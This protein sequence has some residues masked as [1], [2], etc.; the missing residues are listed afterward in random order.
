MDKVT[1]EQ[2]DCLFNPQSIAVIGAADRYDKRGKWAASWGFSILYQVL[3]TSSP[4]KIYAVNR[5]SSAV[6]NLKC[7]KSILDVPEPVDLAVVV[8]PA[9]NVPSAIR[10][11][12]DKK[13]KNIIIISGGF[14]ELNIEG[15]EVQ[16][17]LLTM[18]RGANVRLLG[19]NCMGHFNTHADLSTSVVLPGKKGGVG[20]IS[21]SGNVGSAII[22]NGSRMGIG[23]SK[24][25]STGNEADLHLEDF[26]EYLADDEE[27][28]VITLYVEGLREGKRFMELAKE[29]TK[30]KPVIAFKAGSTEAGTRAAQ[31]HTAA[32]TGTDEIYQ[33]AF[34]Q[35]GI[36]Q[37][38][39]IDELVN[40]A[41]AL[42]CQPLPRSRRVAILTLGGGLGVVAADSCERLN[43]EVAPLLPQTI[44]R[45]NSLLPGIW[46]HGNPVDT[47]GTLDPV[48][49]CLSAL[50]EDRNIDSVL[51][52][53]PV[54]GTNIWDDMTLDEIEKARERGDPGN[55]GLIIKLR[56]EC[57][58]PVIICNLGMVIEQPTQRD[59]Q[60]YTSMERAVRVLAHLAEY[61][62][63][64]NQAKGEKNEP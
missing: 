33:A 19:P 29:I 5:N 36:I 55:L 34:K 42:L 25:I 23:F 58:K 63:Y 12:L 60:I 57:Q 24:Y 4:R 62:K 21:Q 44:D 13:V 61:S 30:R 59:I 10:E 46:S 14:S 20:V 48:F 11:C 64:L 16:Q 2:L 50:L 52:N 22:I 7:Y 49:P 17:E 41:G 9:H 45:L 56:N 40:I 1:K 35:A 54:F 26:L 3:A 38:R 39:S 18:A 27:T 31:S 43:L 47:I 15:A 37:V 53:T 8:I 32:L 51:L 28:K 6:Q